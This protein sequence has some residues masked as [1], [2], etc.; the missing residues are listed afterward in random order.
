MAGVDFPECYTAEIKPP[1]LPEEPEWRLIHIFASSVHRAVWLQSE[2][3]K[4]LMAEFKEL[5]SNGQAVLIEHDL[6][7]SEVNGTIAAAVTTDVKP[8]MEEYYRIW[9]GKIQTLQT[10]CPGY[11]GSFVQPPTKEAPDR[12]T[13]LV[14]FDKP[15]DLE[16][17][18]SSEER[19][20]RL[21]EAEHF[22]NKVAVQRITNSFPGWFPTDA[23]GKGPPNWKIAMLV[24]LGLYPTV[25]LEIKFLN[26][27]LHSLGPALC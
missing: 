2:Q 20:K 24:L 5:A 12:W 4:K 3:Y 1:L 19:K 18:I 25:M 22:V 23:E 11:R 8:E 6:Q 13:T 7:G 14:R 27:Q 21:P 15:A 10:K 17:W 16:H 9:E 26:P